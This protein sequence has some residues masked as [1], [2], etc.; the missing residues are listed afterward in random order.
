MGAFIQ[1]LGWA[2]ERPLTHTST[3]VDSLDHFYTLGSCFKRKTTGVSLALLGRFGLSE[4]SFDV[5][6][7]V[8]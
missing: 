1:K 2:E 3:V 4:Q 8:S 6:V 7:M 5:I